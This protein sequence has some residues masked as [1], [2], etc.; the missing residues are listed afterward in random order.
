MNYRELNNAFKVINNW[1]TKKTKVLNI[2]TRPYNTSYVFSNIINRVLSDGGKI[3]YVWCNTEIQNYYIYK[4]KFYSTLFEGKT[5]CEFNK[6]ID[7]IIIDEVAKVE[8]D[9]D[10][11]II[12]DISKFSKVAVEDIRDAVEAIYWRSMKIIVYTCEIL[13]PIGEKFE[14][15]YLPDTN[16]MVEPRIINTRIR[17][18]QDIP[19][20]L[21][22]YF[23]WFKETK[24]KVVIVIPSEEKL[25]KIFN[26][27]YRT[28]KDDQIRVVRYVRGQS[29]HY[30][31][32]ITDGYSSSIFILTNYIGEYVKEIDYLNVVVLFADDLM[33]SYKKFLYLSGALTL[34]DNVMSEVI[35]VSKE[36]SSHMDL[37][38]NMIREFNKILWE[39]KLI[40]Q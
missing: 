9:Y 3:L 37:A 21:Y 22:E 4:E 23:K 1:Y 12:D 30:I 25:N 24:K 38:K 5:N 33:Y 8:E 36:V 28:L 11:V 40:R 29:F 26:Y 18:D 7:F 17:L 31:K 39:K 16:L 20:T 35:F 6:N 13:F 14:L 15:V 27:Y 10:L 34:K 19:L 32:E 2:K